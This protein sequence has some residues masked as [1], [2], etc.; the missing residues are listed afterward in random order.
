MSMSGNVNCV[1]RDTEGNFWYYT[2]IH[3]FVHELFRNGKASN[4]DMATIQ[5]K[6][7]ALK[8]C[9]PFSIA[10]GKAGSMFSNGRFY[11]VDSDGNEHNS[12]K[13][14]DGK[15][16]S[17]FYRYQKIR[18]LLRKPNLL[19][20]GRQFNKQ[21]EI[22]LKAFGFCP[23][24][25]LRSIRSELP[26]SM[27]IIP[28]ELFH[29]E[30][31]GKL[32]NQTD[33]AG[34]VKSV[35]I[36]WGEE[37]IELQDGDYFI[38][39]DS[40]VEILPINSELKYSTPVDTLSSSVNNWISQVRARGTLIVD[41]GPK[42][43]IS[44]GT[45]GDVHGNSTLT[46][47][48]K[49]AI[50]QNFK[51]KYGLVDKLYSIMVTTAN[52][53]WTPI[54]YNTKELMLH[55]EDEACR[56]LIANTIGL[57]PNVFLSDSKYANQ[58]GAKR[59]AYQDLIIPDAENYA[60]AL[61]EAIAPA[62]VFIKLD[63]TH[64]PILQEDKQASSTALSRASNAIVSLLSNKLITT[65]EARREIAT[66]IDINPDEPEGDFNENRQEDKNEQDM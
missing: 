1:E 28:P 47:K 62:G 52:V 16:D 34:I 7:L 55:E 14:K 38:I 22:N 33:M 8:A 59:D 9:T 53:K 27:I 20:S 11:V 41:G 54:T 29:V 4:I 6:S 64:I 24:Y 25:T 48:E 3:S 44:D 2:Q 60:E 36:D 63:Y 35:Y 15:T 46:P 17:L 39:T 31:S 13:T 26:V 43:I 10:V 66:Y 37:K 49:K 42:G 56:N 40:Q 32:W 5:G 21:I 65:L 58:D 23:V 50:Q 18:A 30:L 12:Y 61:T 57:N 51:D 45:D 19:Q